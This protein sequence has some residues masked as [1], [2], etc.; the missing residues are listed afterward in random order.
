MQPPARKGRPGSALPKLQVSGEK[1]EESL[2][3]RNFTQESAILAADLSG[4]LT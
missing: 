1:A 4:T 2:K 3:T